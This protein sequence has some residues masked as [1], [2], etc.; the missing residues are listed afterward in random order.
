MKQAYHSYICDNHTLPLE[1]GFKCLKHDLSPQGLRS[2]TFTRH[3]TNSASLKALTHSPS[4]TTTV[5][6]PP[7]MACELSVGHCFHRLRPAAAERHRDG[8][9]DGG[10]CCDGLLLQTRSGLQVG[11]FIRPHVDGEAR[12]R[13]SSYS[14]RWRDEVVFEDGGGKGVGHG[15][16][17]VSEK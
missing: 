16:H 15:W 5:S 11:A 7:S 3:R 4:R 12:S 10:G 6:P 17:E 9:C 14:K 2:R 13:I 1:Q 8:R